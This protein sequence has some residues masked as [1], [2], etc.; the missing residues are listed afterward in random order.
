MK[1]KILVLHTGG[2]IGMHATDRGYNTAKN[3]LIKLMANLTELNSDAMPDYDVIEYEPLI[4]SA[5]MTPTTWN[6]IA[7]DIQS[8]YQKYAAFVILHGTDTMAY[9]ASALS[10][11]LENLAK[12][13]IFTGAQLPLE[14]VRTDARENLINTFYLASHHEFNEVGLFFHDVLFR[15]NRTKKTSSV[16]YDAFNSPNFSALAKIETDIRWNKHLLL[17]PPIEGFQ[18]RKIKKINIATIRLFPGIFPDYVDKMCSDDL[19]ALIVGTYGVG[20]APTEDKALMQ[21]F[22]RAENRGVMLVN[23]TQCPHGTV[24]MQ[25]YAVGNELANLG[26]VS[27]FDMTMEAVIGK[28]YYLFSCDLKIDEIKQQFQMNLRGELTR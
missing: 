19:A 21:A 6:K 11:M 25:T 7:E 8:Y 26:F 3:H 18:I 16:R 4:D 23:S 20:N 15:G 24:N 10:F 14:A 28:L 12:P 22:K 2:T 27:S 17:S 1:K 13:I 5:N 9:S